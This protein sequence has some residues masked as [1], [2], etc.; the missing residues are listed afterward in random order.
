MSNIPKSWDSYQPLIFTA[1]MGD[2]VGAGTGGTM[3]GGLAGA[4][5]TGEIFEMAVLLGKPSENH[6]KIWGKPWENISLENM[7]N[8]GENPWKI[9][10]KPW[11][12]HGK[13]NRTSSEHM[14]KSLEHPTIKK[15]SGFL[16]RVPLASSSRHGWSWRLVLKPMVTWGWVRIQEVNHEFLGILK[17]D[18]Y[19]SDFNIWRLVKTYM[20][21]YTI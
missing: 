11:E 15:D 21:L 6:W 14:G 18:P 7:E 19:P 10:G 13:N 16:S 8:M 12:N 4:A 5:S 20:K 1:S 3:G 9:I 2:M 17:F